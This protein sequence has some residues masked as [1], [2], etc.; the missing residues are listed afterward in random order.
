[1]VVAA[2]T[3]RVPIYAVFGEQAK[4]CLECNCKENLL[5]GT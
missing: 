4:P 3:T 2:A 1:M 5:A